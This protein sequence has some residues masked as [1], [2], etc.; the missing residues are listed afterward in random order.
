[1]LSTHLH[2]ERVGE[3]EG[4]DEERDG[5]ER[6]RRVRRMT[7]RELR[8]VGREA[9]ADLEGGGEWEG[10]KVDLGAKE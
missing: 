1:M 5:N 6:G 10:R 2:A 3:D 4:S 7:G 8:V 9:R